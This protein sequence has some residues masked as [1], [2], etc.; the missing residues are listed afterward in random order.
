MSVKK[1]DCPVKSVA[2]KKEF[3]T[4]C[5]PPLE[6]EALQKLSGMNTIVM[7]VDATPTRVGGLLRLPGGERTIY[8]YSVNWS[9]YFEIEIAT[10]FEML[11]TALAL[12]LFD[13]YIQAYRDRYENF[14]VKTDSNFFEVVKGFNDASEFNLLIE[15]KHKVNSLQGKFQHSAV[16]QNDPDIQNADYLSR[17]EIPFGLKFDYEL[18]ESF[19]TE[20]TPV[21]VEKYT[22]ID[23][24]AIASTHTLKSMLDSVP[25]H[26]LK[27]RD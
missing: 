24:S 12:N 9:S 23:L 11:N 10:Q 2:K 16:A 27:K 26:Y 25:N 5:P 22:L 8:Y 15:V 20:N 13:P 4:S 7:A 18:V 3:A 6:M 17:A 21:P 19:Y 1:P 14:V